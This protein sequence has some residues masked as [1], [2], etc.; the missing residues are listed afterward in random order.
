MNHNATNNAHHALDSGEVA[1]PHAGNNAS[2]QY[3]MRGNMH[4]NDAALTQITGRLLLGNLAP[5]HQRMILALS[6]L[7]TGT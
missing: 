4:V 3:G 7:M 2:K 5:E 1:W 6:Y